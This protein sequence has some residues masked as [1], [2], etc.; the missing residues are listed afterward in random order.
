MSDIILVDNLPTPSSRILQALDNA[1]LHTVD[2]LTLDP[3]EIH[4]RT[5]ISVIDVQLLVK[6]LIAALSQRV[7]KDVK[8]AEERARGLSFLTTGDRR[9]DELIGGGIPTGA[10]TEITGER[11]AEPEVDI[12]RRF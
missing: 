2:L 10:L 12:V 3:F 6:D 8:T 1:N 7:E 9:V 5:Q 11:Y 4:R